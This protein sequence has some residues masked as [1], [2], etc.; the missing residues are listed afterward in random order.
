MADAFK[1]W[2]TAEWALATKAGGCKKK[3][4]AKQLFLKIHFFC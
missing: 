1:S 2:F 3:L 4:W